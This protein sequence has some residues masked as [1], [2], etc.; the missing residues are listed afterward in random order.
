M[1]VGETLKIVNFVQLK[2]QVNLVTVIFLTYWSTIKIYE[3]T[4]LRLQDL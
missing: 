3:I 1:F 4:L 2:F